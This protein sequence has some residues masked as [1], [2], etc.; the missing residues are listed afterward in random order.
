MEKKEEL[1]VL[2]NELK[3]KELFENLELRKIISIGQIEEAVNFDTEHTCFHS[4]DNI[5]DIITGLFIS[6]VNFGIFYKDEYIGMISSYYQYYKDLG[7]LEFCIC[8]KDEYRNLGIGKFCYD[9]LIRESFKNDHIK[10]IHL[11]I[12]EDNIGSRLLAEKCGFKLYPGYK[13]NN[14][15]KDEQGNCYPQVQYL[16]KKKDYKKK[17]N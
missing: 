4:Y 14:V 12:K 7:R 5:K 15:F 8:L 11:S 13:V 3:K 9:I 16:L 17:K 6:A 2:L 1:V 10:S